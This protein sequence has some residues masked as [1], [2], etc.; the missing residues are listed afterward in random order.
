MPTSKYFLLPTALGKRPTISKPHYAN[1]QGLDRGLRTSP[2]W[3]MLG[4]NLW[5]WSHF[6]TYSCASFCMFGHQ[7][8][9]VIAL[10][11]KDLPPMWLLQIPSC[12]SSR[13][14][15]ED[16]GW[17]HSKYG[18]KKERL[19]SFWSSDSQNRGA[20]HRI[21]STS[22][23]SDVKVSSFKN[24]IMGSIQLDPTLICWTWDVTPFT[25]MGLYK[26]STR[27]TRG[28]L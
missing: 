10:W 4:A 22:N 17:M 26:S 14:S 12:N 7:Y 21:F 15:S 24:D 8:P 18:P 19:Y 27:M 25:S 2:G 3:C 13:R 28:R 1:G 16:S 11:D 20:F 9:C 6:F 5:H 23:L